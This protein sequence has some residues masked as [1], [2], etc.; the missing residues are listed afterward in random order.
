V[1]FN[2]RYGIIHS[3]CTFLLNPGVENRTLPSSMNS[4]ASAIRWVPKPTPTQAHLEQL[5]HQLNVTQEVA[6]LLAHR[7]ITTFE[8]ARTY[9]RPEESTWHDP[10]L[11]KDM[12]LAVGDC[13]EPLRRGERHGVW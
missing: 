8:E 12:E 3:T 7:G 10:F 11:M 5:V 9:F 1:Q 2:K 13:Y 6:M 4:T